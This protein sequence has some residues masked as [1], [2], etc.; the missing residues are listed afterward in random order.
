MAKCLV[1][2]ASG[3]LA[4]CKECGQFWCTVCARSEKGKGRYPKQTGANVCP[5]CGTYDKIEAMR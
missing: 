2:N 5:F 1:C 3:T 4:R